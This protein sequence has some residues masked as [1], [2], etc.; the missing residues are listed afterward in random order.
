M[1]SWK[2]LSRWLKLPRQLRF[3][4][5][6]KWFVVLALAVGITD[7]NTGL[8]LLYLALASMLSLIFTSEL[9]L[10]MSLRRVRF[11]LTGSSYV[12]SN[13]E[14]QLQAI[15]VSH[16]HLIPSFSLS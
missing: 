1:S 14:F 4:R 2:S 13:Q 9:L 6:R 11:S 10:E 15:L 8:N 7:I 3:T 12:F 5:E 16:K